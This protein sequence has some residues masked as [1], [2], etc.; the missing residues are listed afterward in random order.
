MT[1]SLTTSLAPRPRPQVPASTPVLARTVEVTKGDVAKCALVE[2]TAAK[3]TGPRNENNNLLDGM[4]NQSMDPEEF[5]AQTSDETEVPRTQHSEVQTYGT[6]QT[7]LDHPPP[8]D[9]W[10]VPVP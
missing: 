6:P 5:S 8:H 2:P 4:C 10:R 9:R 7:P 1:P 3:G